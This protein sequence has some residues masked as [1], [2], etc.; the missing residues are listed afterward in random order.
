MSELFAR[1][2]KRGLIERVADTRDR[3]RTLVWLTD[4]G[5]SLLRTETRVLSEQ[6]LT[7]AFEQ[8]DVT[9]RTSLLAVFGALLA[10][11]PPDTGYD[12]TGDQT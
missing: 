8:L 2:E 11:N 7:S 5:C 12:E 1:L 3:R 10:T 6:L 9:E 4:N